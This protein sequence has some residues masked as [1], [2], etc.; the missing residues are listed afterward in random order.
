MSVTDAENWAG[1]YPITFDMLINRGL[2]AS[3]FISLVMAAKVIVVRHAPMQVKNVDDGARNEIGLEVLGRC[4][5][6]ALG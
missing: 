4:K 6:V 3:D 1:D 5:M 2:L